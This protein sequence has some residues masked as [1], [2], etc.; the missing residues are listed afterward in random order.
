MT[1]REHGRD[2]V[3]DLLDR[4]CGGFQ[5]L[6]GAAEPLA[7]QPGLQGRC[8]GRLEVPDELSPAHQ[9]AGR[10]L[11]QDSWLSKSA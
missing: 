4:D 6:L 8:Y 11:I 7:E 9:R 2:A 5:E 10:K 1:A 3:S